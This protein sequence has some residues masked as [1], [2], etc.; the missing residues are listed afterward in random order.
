V[1]AFRLSFRTPLQ[2]HKQP[3][4]ET[5]KQT[6]PL[7]FEVRGFVLRK[8]LGQG[9]GGRVFLGCSGS[10]RGQEGKLAAIKIVNKRQ[11]NAKAVRMARREHSILGEMPPH[12]H[13][14]H[15]Y[16]VVENSD[17][18]CL[19]MQFAEGGDL[20]DYVLQCGK[21]PLS[22]A[23]R[24]FRQLLAAVNHIHRSGTLSYR[25]FIPCPLWSL[26]ML[27]SPQQASCTG[28]SS[29][30]TSFSIRTATSCSVTSVWAAS[31]AR[32]PPPTPPAEV[33]TMPVRALT[34]IVLL[35]DPH[36]LPPPSSRQPRRYSRRITISGPRW[37]SGAV[38][39]C[40]T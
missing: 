38:G 4:Q 26:H 36:G 21:L 14:V 24:L 16:H 8:Q 18:L 25:A 23:W 30:R 27:T 19:V 11:N 13:V 37:I 6:E 2:T 5:E 34:A 10:G 35:C 33:S 40:C 3:S 17:R 15:L 9:A 20:F 32:S 12:P 22:E 28:I 31:G 1:V 39:R 29:R 7:V